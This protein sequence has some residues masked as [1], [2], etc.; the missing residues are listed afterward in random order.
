MMTVQTNYPEW[1]NQNAHRKYPFAD[2]ASLLSN[3]GWLLSNGLLLDARVYLLGA[4]GTLYLASIR[5]VSSQTV[6]TVADSV[7]QKTCT[8]TIDPTAV[9]D[10]YAL[11]DAFGRPAGV[12]VLDQVLA[13]T[14]LSTNATFTAATAP[15]VASVVASVPD[16]VLTGV[17][18]GNTV[19]TGTI[20]VV[21]M[22][23]VKLSVEGSNVRVDVV[24]DP[25]A[26]RRL[27]LEGV[28][29]E[30]IRTSLKAIKVYYTDP[31]IGEFLVGVV[32]PDTRGEVHIVAGE[33]LREDNV[34]R[35]LP[36][37]SGI[38]ISAVRG[39]SGGN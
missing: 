30:P 38:N 36:T 9:K 15:F 34:L 12:L 5:R 23:G 31:I 19:M 24:G 4:V 13:A 28:V 39:W 1:R 26:Y 7:S 11:T 21:A 29:P 27:Y 2:N 37:S 6:L 32:E 22:N 18:V 20:P 14:L 16:A 17:Q 35:V 3:E 8:A 25:F 10:T 33:N